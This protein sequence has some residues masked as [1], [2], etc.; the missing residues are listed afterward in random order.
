MEKQKPFE[1][2]C[3]CCRAKLRVDPELRKVLS[4]EVPRQTKVTDLADAARALREKENQRDEQF[5]KSV[6]AQRE[7]SKLL[8]KKFADAFEKAKDAPVE[9]PVRDFD[10]D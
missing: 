4:H 2:E 10:L 3:P 8:E 1:I 9:R 7:R 6:E 5:Q